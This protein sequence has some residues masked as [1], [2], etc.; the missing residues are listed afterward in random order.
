MPLAMTQTEREA[1]LADVHV[2]VI[3]IE[4]KDGPPLAVPIW[5]DYT[6][7]RGLWVITQQNSQKGRA[8]AEAGRFTLCA[9]TEKPPEYR[10]VSVSGPIVDVREA[11]RERDS[12]PMAHRYFGAELGDLYVNSQDQGGNRVFTM[13]PERWRTVDYGKFTGAS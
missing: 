6:P 7:E 2:G 13:R 4:V 9:Q 5:Y 1:F 10:Y 3:G 12:R 8:L 11:D